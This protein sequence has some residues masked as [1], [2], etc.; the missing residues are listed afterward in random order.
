[1]TSVQTNRPRLL[2]SLA[3][4]LLAACDQSVDE[5]QPD[6]ASVADSSVADRQLTETLLPPDSTG[7]DASAPGKTVKVSYQGKT[8]VVDLNKP[9]PVTFE[10]TAHARL[11]EVIK[12]AQPG[13]TN[14][15]KMT[16]DFTSGDGYKPGTKSNCKALIPVAGAEFARGYID[17]ASRK[18]RWDLSLQ[19]P[20]CLYIKDLAEITLA[21]K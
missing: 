11:D 10:G 3:L 5:G 8:V 20:G 13:I 21:P 18:L 6:S 1:M 7:P 19:Y 2:C 9:A 17:V 4:L 16:A 14:Q 15:T 12:L